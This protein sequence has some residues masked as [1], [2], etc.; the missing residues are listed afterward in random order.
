MPTGAASSKKRITYS[1]YVA[2]PSS[3]DGADGIV[4]GVSNAHLSLVGYAMD[5]GGTDGTTSLQVNRVRDESDTELLSSTLDIAND[6][7]TV[8]N[9]TNSTFQN[10]ALVQGDILRL[11]LDSLAT[12]GSGFAWY[13]EIHVDQD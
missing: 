4:V 10:N 6:A 2:S 5:V 8:S 3:G 13:I 11:D 1:G 12:G 9:F 7:S